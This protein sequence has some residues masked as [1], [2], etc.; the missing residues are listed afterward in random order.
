MWRVLEHYGILDKN[1]NLVRYMYEDSKCCVRMVQEHT[2]CFSIEV[3]VRQ[4]D[5]LSPLLFNLVLDFILRNLDHTDG[6]ITCKGMKKLKD[7]DYADD[8]CLL[9]ESYEEMQR[10]TDKLAAC[11]LSF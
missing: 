10:L 8:I 11:K 9:A 7:L 5:V 1:I 4:G 3:E 2:D 6:G